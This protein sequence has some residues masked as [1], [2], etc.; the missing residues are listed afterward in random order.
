MLNVLIARP[1]PTPDRAEMAA[2]LLYRAPSA[3]APRTRPIDVSMGADADFGF[4]LN[5]DVAM[6]SGMQIGL[7][8]PGLTHV[9]ISNEECRILQMH[10]NLERWLGIGPEDP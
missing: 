5:Q 1:G 2:F 7:E 8:Q 4:V 3:A 9:A 10:R 6:A